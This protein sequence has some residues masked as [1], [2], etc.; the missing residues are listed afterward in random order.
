MYEEARRA[1]DVSLL[2]DQYCD[3]DCRWRELSF[4]LQQLRGL[5]GTTLG[6]VRQMTGYCDDLC[7]VLE[8]EPQ[9]DRE[10]VFR[11]TVETTA[12]LET[13]LDD[14]HSELYDVNGVAGIVRECRGLT[15]HSRRLGRFANEAAYD[16]LNTK[17]LTF[18]SDWRKFAAKLY[19][20][21][22]RYC[23]RSIRRI[24]SCNQRVLEQLWTP[25]AIDRD[26][27]RYISHS[28]AGEVSG[29]FENIT[30]GSLV[31]LPPAE[32]QSLLQLAR[33]LNGHCDYFRG[34]VDNNSPLNELMVAYRR[35]DDQWQP[36]D[37]YL[38]IV[39]SK[40]VVSSRR[41]ITAQSRELRGLLGVPARLD[42]A[43]AI[44]LAASLEEMAGHLHYDTRRYGRYYSSSNFRN[45]AYQRSDAFFAQAKN[46]H[47]QLQQGANLG[48]INASCNDVVTS[49]GAFSSAVTAMPRNGL[50]ASRSQYMNDSRQELLPVIAELATLLGT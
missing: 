10:A 44:Q 19:P 17:Y 40:P 50:S 22:N 2:R 39:T 14:I 34:C 24:H 35:I 25:L 16:E 41:L 3:L 18:V 43:H 45:Q 26:Y 37:R 13:L 5:D 27:L 8:L 20:Q 46:L 42:R 48:R 15:E 36:A 23:D 7:R 30:I 47:A 21:Q 6:Y 1:Q 4:R 29:M 11:L 31:Q 33:E 38:R 12:H 28:M 49:W 9:F 32:Q